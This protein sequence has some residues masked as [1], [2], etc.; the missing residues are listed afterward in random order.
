[1]PLSLHIHTSVCLLPQALESE[2][3]SCQLHQWIDLVFGYKQR[4]PEATR[5]TNVFYYLTYEGAVNL[6]AIT[7]PVMRE[8]IENQIRSFGQTPSQLL[9]EPHPPRSSPMHIVSI[10]DVTAAHRAA[11]TA[12]LTHAYREYL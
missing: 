11:P 9:T 10:Y 2:F 4:G 7:D 6:E 3:V 5:A 12:Q 8:A 1:M